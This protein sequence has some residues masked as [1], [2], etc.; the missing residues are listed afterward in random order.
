V[1][2]IHRH[3]HWHYYF[4]DEYEACSS[5]RRQLLDAEE[6][7]CLG[8]FT[9][10]TKFSPLTFSCCSCFCC[11]CGWCG[12]RCAA[13]IWVSL[14]SR[15]RGDGDRVC[16]LLP[17]DVSPAEFASLY[18]EGYAIAFRITGND[19]DAHDAVQMAFFKIH[20]RPESPEHLRALFYCAVRRTALD[21]VRNRKR[22][23]PIEE[24][25]IPCCGNDSAGDV[26]DDMLPLLHDAIRTLPSADQRILQ[27]H[28]FDGLSH[29][30]VADRLHV[31]VTTVNM[32]LHT[33]RC[34][35]KTALLVLAEH[36]HA[37]LKAADKLHRAGVQTWAKTTKSHCNSA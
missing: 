19:A 27:M 11:H 5:C 13:E 36:D 20:R 28:Y 14:F 17:E 25:R 22:H 35:L 34:R 37:D 30:E 33:A 1:S 8:T 12:G 21:I 32:R 10:D 3:C 29:Q 23:V 16:R 26:F 7:Y 18:A 4:G 24:Q 31:P 15:S 2:T 6:F 9:R